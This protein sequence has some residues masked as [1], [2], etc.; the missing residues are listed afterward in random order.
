M[1]PRVYIILLTFIQVLYKNIFSKSQY[2]KVYIT[3]LYI[4]TGIPIYHI[5]LT[6]AY[7]GE[8]FCISG[9]ANCAIEI[10]MSE[11]ET[12]EE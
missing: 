2:T 6:N 10:E 5:G 3:N 8:V 4:H 7:S 9:K 1:T 11:I 12:L